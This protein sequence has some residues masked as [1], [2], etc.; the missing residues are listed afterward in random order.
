MKKFDTVQDM[1][2]YVVNFLLDQ[3]CQSADKGGSCMYRFGSLRCAAGSLLDD[4]DNVVEGN[5]VDQI[6]AFRRN[7]SAEQLNALIV[8]QGMHDCAPKEDGDGFIGYVANRTLELQNV[9]E[10]ETMLVPVGAS[11]VARCKAVLGIQ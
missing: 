9:D 1:C 8:L 6:V 2:D 10:C 5:T 3:G 11:T 7:F 4:D